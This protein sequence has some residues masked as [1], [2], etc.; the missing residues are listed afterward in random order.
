MKNKKVI[1]ISIGVI[2]IVIAT[3]LVLMNLIGN[4]KG[5]GINVKTEQ[6]EGYKRTSDTKM[7]FT[8]DER[9][10]AY[11]EALKNDNSDVLISYL[12]EDYI[13]SNGKDKNSVVQ[14]LQKY[15]NYNSYISLEMYEDGAESYITYYVKGKIDGKNV[16]YN[17]EL[18]KNHKTFNICPINENEYE[19]KI[20]ED[21]T[22]NN[23]ENK[24]ID[25]KEYN[26]FNYKD[27]EGKEELIA[28][29]YYS[30][31]IRA[32]LTDSEEAYKFLDKEYKE[33]NG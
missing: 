2:I 28:R 21:G 3:I 25:E 30:E 18:D 9:I 31:Y 7:F 24:S 15:N 6:Q 14:G 16:F 12:N 23:Y 29:L 27:L 32:M 1:L 33:K 11:N 20:Q 4:K 13:S 19:K 5:V 26:F 10:K 22:G 8:V 17:V